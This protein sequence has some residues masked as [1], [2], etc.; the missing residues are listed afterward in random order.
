MSVKLRMRRLGNRNRP[1]Y[2]I[3]A[4]DSRTRRDGAVIE[5]LGFY[6][7]LEKDQAKAVGLKLDR[8]AYWISVGAQPSDTVATLLKRKG[9]NPAPGTKLADQKALAPA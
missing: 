8:A 3:N 5:E 6:N 7:P 2:R 4:I 1:F 9:I